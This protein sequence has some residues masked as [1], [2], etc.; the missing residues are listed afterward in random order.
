MDEQT[1]KPWGHPHRFRSTHVPRTRWVVALTLGM[2]VVEVAGGLWTQSM[3][4][5]ADGLHLT[6]HVLAIGVPAMQVVLVSAYVQFA[7]HVTYPRISG[8]LPK[9]FRATDLL[10]IVR[11]HCPDPRGSPE[12]S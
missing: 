10:A 4:L 8:L 1:L 2:M 3:A 11:H 6:T 12:P 9:P 5:L 7:R